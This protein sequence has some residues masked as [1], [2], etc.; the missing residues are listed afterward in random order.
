M[1]EAAI[2]KFSGFDWKE[3]ESD[4]TASLLSLSEKASLGGMRWGVVAVERSSEEGGGG[5]EGLMKADF[6]AG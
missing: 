4:T 5:G 1:S 3:E 6:C 2:W